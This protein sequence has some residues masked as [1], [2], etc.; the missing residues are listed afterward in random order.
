MKDDTAVDSKPE[1]KKPKIPSK[2][3]PRSTELKGIQSI[4]QVIV[5]TIGGHGSRIFFA[6]SSHSVIEVRHQTDDLE[7]F[8]TQEMTILW[9]PGEKK[10]KVPY[11]GI[12]ARMIATVSPLLD[13]FKEFKKK[14]A[15]VLHMSCPS[16]LHLQY[17]GLIHCP[18]YRE[19]FNSDVE[20]QRR[21]KSF[22]P[23]IHLAVF[24]QDVNVILREFKNSRFGELK[25]YN[26]SQL[27]D[28]VTQ[29]SCWDW[30]LEMGTMHL[31]SKKE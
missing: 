18:I 17:M 10:S 24:N 21:M 12:E 3:I 1:S 2:E 27:I 30:R 19:Y 14:V 11:I 15:L 22:G 23:F 16:E 9:E 25:K 28:I 4:H 5:R 31:T 20:I 26:S 6:N 8:T 7:H 13:Q 29:V